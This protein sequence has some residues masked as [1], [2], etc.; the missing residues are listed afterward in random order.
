MSREHREL[1]GNK[2]WR[3]PGFVNIGGRG[4]AGPDPRPPLRERRSGF[5]IED[6]AEPEEPSGGVSPR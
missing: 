3:A 2:L 4:G 5:V 6:G 1:H